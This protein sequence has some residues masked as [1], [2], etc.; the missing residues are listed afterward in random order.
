MNTRKPSWRREP[1]VWLLIALPGAAVLASLYTIY[2]AI[3]TSDGLVAD[4]YYQ[5]GMTINR[6]LDRDIRARVLGLSVQIRSDTADVAVHL[7]GTALTHYPDALMLGLRHAT[8][9]GTDQT[10][11]LDHH[12][13]GRYFST[14]RLPDNGHYDLEIAAQDW[15]L[16]GR[17]DLPL[18]LPLVL[19]SSE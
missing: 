15:R 17:L 1:M 5:Q 14:A 9:A 8:R 19:D 6:Q 13:D 12:G 2:L 4:D 18:R 11:R 10:L 7:Q 3:S 16:T